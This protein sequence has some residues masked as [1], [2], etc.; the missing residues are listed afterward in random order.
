M[1]LRYYAA[2]ASAASSLPIIFTTFS[3]AA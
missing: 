2:D 3:P 1:L